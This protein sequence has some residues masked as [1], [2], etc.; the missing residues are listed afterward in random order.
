MSSA[1]DFPLGLVSYGLLRETLGASRLSIDGDFSLD[2]GFLLAEDAT[3]AAER[4]SGALAADRE[5][6][7]PATFTLAID[8]GAGTVVYLPEGSRQVPV[9]LKSPADRRNRRWERSLI[10]TSRM[11]KF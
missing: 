11:Y 7:P 6:Q 4:A 2:Q 1:E 8:D 9:I 3:S 10:G 5:V